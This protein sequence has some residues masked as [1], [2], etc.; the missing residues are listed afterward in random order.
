MSWYN[1]IWVFPGSLRLLFKPISSLSPKKSLQAGPGKI[2][3]D[4]VIINTG[5]KS[6]S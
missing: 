1:V 5:L 4:R 6:R 3:T 2:R